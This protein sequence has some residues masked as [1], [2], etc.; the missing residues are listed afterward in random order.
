M[1]EVAAAAVVITSPVTENSVNAIEG[2]VRTQFPEASIA[3]GA[4]LLVFLTETGIFES[5]GAARKMIQ[6]GGVSINRQ[7]INEVQLRVDKSHLLHDQYILVQ[8]GKKNYFL[9][10]VKN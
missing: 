5:K 3:E 1:A 2:I 9:V 8:V 4:D 10:E 6:N 7:K